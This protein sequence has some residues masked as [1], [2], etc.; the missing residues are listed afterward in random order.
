M[1]EKDIYINNFKK[2]IIATSKMNIILSDGTL[3]SYLDNK[4]AIVKIDDKTI[5][6]EI[7]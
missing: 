2:K 7:I 1:V 6:L 3:I 5:F 4:I